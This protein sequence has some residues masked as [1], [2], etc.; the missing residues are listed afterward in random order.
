MASVKFA[1]VVALRR[2]LLRN[3]RS[4]LHLSP[5]CPSPQLLVRQQHL[6]LARVALQQLQLEA[7]RQQLLPVL[8]HL[9]QLR[10]ALAQSL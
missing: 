3:M 9:L 10:P 6:S 1:V 7:L 4:L 2:F 8:P 5:R